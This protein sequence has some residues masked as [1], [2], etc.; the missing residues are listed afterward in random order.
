MLVGILLNV[1]LVGFMNDNYDVQ[2]DFV[3]WMLIG[4]FFSV[5]LLLLVWLLLM[6]WIY[7]VDF[8][9]LEVV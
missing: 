9:I 8:I 4:I 1:F 2:L 3:K 7:L 6:C 5:I